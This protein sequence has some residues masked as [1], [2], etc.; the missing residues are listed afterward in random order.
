MVM[1]QTQT[2]LFDFSDV[3]LDFCAGSKNLFPDRFK[4][5]LSQGYNVQTVTGVAIVGD[6]VTFTYG[7][8]HGY[9][10]DRVLKIDSGALASINGGEFWIDSVTVNTVTMTIDNAPISA[11]A[12][13][14]TRIASLGWELVYEVGM[15]HVYKL[16]TISEEDLYARF[17][18]QNVATY[19]N[20]IAPCLGMSYDPASGY[21]TD[22]ASIPSTRN[23]PNATTGLKWDFTFS[24]SS[25][26]VNY[27]YNQGYSTYGKAMVVGS[28]Y[29]FFV[30]SN[31]YST[32]GSNIIN[33]FMP[34]HC[35]D[36][37][38]LANK[39]CVFVN[40][41]NTANNGLSANRTSEWQAYVGSISVIIDIKNTT[42]D[43]FILNPQAYASY[44][45]SRID[46]FQYTT[47]EP[48]RIYERQTGQFLGYAVASCY[49]LK[50]GSQAPT[51]IPTTT[52]SSVFIE[53]SDVL[54]IIHN[55][56]N[57]GDAG[58]SAWMCFPIEEVKLVD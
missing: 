37:D 33:G 48:V 25:G 18:F 38:A 6:Q 31:Y 58:S 8:A 19:R 29:H 13:F 3:G 23:V 47:A 22:L 20:T 14:T 27:T 43:A 45:P 44:L 39:V 30:L 42:S 28:P 51:N 24:G 55:Q 46:P 5:M 40:N 10:A 52:P 32:A 36:F 54:A 41:S 26:E 57:S 34:V 2:K 17:V 56:T 49:R 53:D 21:I 12:G 35:F 50:Y 1:K 9:V 7:G 11:A 4:K 15:V 16:K